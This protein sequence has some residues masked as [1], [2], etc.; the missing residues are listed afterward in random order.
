MLG[1]SI[2]YAFLHA[3]YLLVLDSEGLGSIFA[4]LTICFLEQLMFLFNLSSSILC[5]FWSIVLFSLEY[6]SSLPR[7]IKVFPV[8]NNILWLQDPRFRIIFARNSTGYI[9]NDQRI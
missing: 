7:C 5:L 2:L 6:V 8:T 4:V 1:M 3:C 9:I